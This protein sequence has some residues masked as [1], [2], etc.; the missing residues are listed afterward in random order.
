MTFN[1]VSKTKSKFLEALSMLRT[2]NRGQREWFLAALFI[3][4]ILLAG[5]DGEWFP[6]PNLVGVTL[7]GFCTLWRK[8]KVKDVRA[9]KVPSEEGR[10]FLREPAYHPIRPEAEIALGLWETYQ[11]AEGDLRRILCA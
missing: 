3:F 9:A 5:C 11:G 2:R 10:I 8:Q 4:G 1:T 6:V 7:I